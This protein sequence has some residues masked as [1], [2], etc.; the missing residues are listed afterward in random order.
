MSQE[1]AL[2]TKGKTQVDFYMC[3]QTSTP[4]QLCFPVLERGPVSQPTAKV[5]A[6]VATRKEVSD[7]ATVRILQAHDLYSRL[8]FTPLLKAVSSQPAQQGK[9]EKG[10]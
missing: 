2:S 8:V 9:K 1:L 7:I 3:P 6:K 10:M 5:S 4:N